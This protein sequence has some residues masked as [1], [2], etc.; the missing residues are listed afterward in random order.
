MGERVAI[1]RCRPDISEELRSA[2]TS[3]DVFIQPVPSAIAGPHVEQGSIDCG[4]KNT[5]TRRS[6]VPFGSHS[7]SCFAVASPAIVAC[8]YQIRCGRISRSVWC[9]VRR[10]STLFVCLCPIPRA[11][12]SLQCRNAGSSSCCSRRSSSCILAVTCPGP[13]VA[14]GRRVSVPGLRHAHPSPATEGQV[15]DVDAAATLRQFGCQRR[16]AQSCAD[17]AREITRT[18]GTAQC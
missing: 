17:K 9:V 2:A 15:D 7:P 16:F 13:A 1:F 14:A 11:T 8:G 10:T 18:A 3:G 6:I 4:W 5:L 12:V